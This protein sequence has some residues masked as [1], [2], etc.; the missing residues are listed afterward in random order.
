MKRISAA[1]DQYTVDM[2][3]PDFLLIK[4]GPWGG[5]FSRPVLVAVPRFARKPHGGVAFLENLADLDLAFGGAPPRTGFYLAPGGANIEFTQV[6]SAQ[7]LKVR[8]WE[9]GGRPHFGLRQRRLRGG[10]GCRQARFD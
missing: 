5:C 4:P 9:R 1:G 10:G 8:V 7:H 2:G 6:I 3:E